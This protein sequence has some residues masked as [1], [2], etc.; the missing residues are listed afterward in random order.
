MQ[1]ENNQST[2][3][4]ARQIHEV[5]RNSW[6]CAEDEGEEEEDDYYEATGQMP[7]SSKRNRLRPYIVTRACYMRPSAFK[8]RSLIVTIHAKRGRNSACR[9]TCTIQYTWFSLSN[10]HMARKDYILHNTETFAAWRPQLLGVTLTQLGATLRQLWNA[11]SAQR[12]L[13]HFSFT[14]GVHRVLPKIGR[15]W[16]KLTMHERSERTESWDWEEDSSASKDW[17]IGHQSRP[18]KDK[19]VMTVCL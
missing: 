9:C 19:M 17:R 16:R 13:N 4:S 1:W 12:R 15:E 6:E 8:H 5:K 10:L 14:I 18:E 2:V 11:W 7:S 3:S